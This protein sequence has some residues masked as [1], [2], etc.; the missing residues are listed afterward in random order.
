MEG[1]GPGA[2]PDDGGWPL[3]T[4]V[5]HP[6]REA[7]AHSCPLA[8]L[9]LSCTVAAAYR[10]GKTAPNP[11]PVADEQPGEQGQG[12]EGIGAWAAHGDGEWLLSTAVG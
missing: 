10:T 3:C 9:P 1:Q 5:R 6:E 11:F 12:G 2:A 4:T 7:M 8:P